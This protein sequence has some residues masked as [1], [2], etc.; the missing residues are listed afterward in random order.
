[1]ERAVAE[2]R[3]RQERR[4][5]ERQRELLVAEL[6]HRVKNTLA[7]VIA[8]ARQTARRSRSVTEYRD[9]LLSRLHALSEAHA[10]VF[11]ANW[12]EASLRQVIERT[13]APFRPKDDERLVIDGPEIKVK[14][15]AALSLTLVF[16]EL[17]TNA[18]KHGALSAEHGRVSARWKTSS[19]N[20]A[21][22]RVELVWKEEGGPAVSPPTETGFGTLILQRSVEH[23]L[24]GRARFSYPDTGLVCEIAFSTG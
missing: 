14:P 20:G 9:T 13:L 21:G 23:E 1:V 8:I 12:N 11:E 5:A 16:H 6:S 7:A 15:K 3:E 18:V 4:R 2:A 10:L 22:P 24:D 19:A 17:M